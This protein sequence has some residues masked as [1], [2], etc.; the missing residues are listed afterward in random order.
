MKRIRYMLILENFINRP[1]D[2]TPHSRSERIMLS[3]LLTATA[4]Q[5]L[6]KHGDMRAHISGVRLSC[7]RFDIPPLIRVELRW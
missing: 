3:S 4:L 7:A 6:P 1:V 2:N 5:G